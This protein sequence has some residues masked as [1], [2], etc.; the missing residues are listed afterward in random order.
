MSMSAIER[1]LADEERRQQFTAHANRLALEQ[2][3]AE[4]LGEAVLGEMRLEFHDSGAVVT[5]HGDDFCIDAYADVG[6]E[7][8]GLTLIFTVIDRAKSSISGMHWSFCDALRHARRLH[9]RRP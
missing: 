9:S 5:L 2:T 1:L 7:G 3:L 6:S 8:V 4:E